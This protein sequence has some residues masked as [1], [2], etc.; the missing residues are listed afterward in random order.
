MDNGRTNEYSRP[1]TPDT[2]SRM[3]PIIGLSEAA[4]ARLSRGAAPK[5]VLAWWLRQRT[6]L[7]QRWL[8]ERLAMNHYTRVTQAV[9]RSKQPL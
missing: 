2:T 1:V 6:A 9:N 7:P 3:R 4:L 8:I 5:V